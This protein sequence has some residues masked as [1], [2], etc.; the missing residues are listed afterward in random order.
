M[1]LYICFDEQGWPERVL[2]EKASSLANANTRIL[3]LARRF[4]YARPLPEGCGRLVVKYR[5]DAKK[6]G[7]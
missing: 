4:H 2:L 7:G 3:A 1:V 5:P 6:L